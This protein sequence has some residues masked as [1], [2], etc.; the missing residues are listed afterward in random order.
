MDC[1]YPCIEEE[2]E[3]NHFTNYEIYVGESENYS[4]N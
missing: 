2:K 4:E 3:E 1:E